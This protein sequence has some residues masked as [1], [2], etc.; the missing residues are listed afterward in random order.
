M[1][2]V[3]PLYSLTRQVEYSLSNPLVT[4]GNK[5]LPDLA[6]Y[7]QAVFTSTKENYT[8]Y[9]WPVS[10][11]LSPLDRQVSGQLAQICQAQPLPVDASPTLTSIL[12]FRTPA[13]YSENHH[14]DS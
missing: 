12:S 6:P 4:A 9:E 10:N 14:L 2:L 8:G 7:G 3:C 5:L 11:T 13:N 1:K